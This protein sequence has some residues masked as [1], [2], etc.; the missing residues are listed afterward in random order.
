MRTGIWDVHHVLRSSK[1]QARSKSPLTE[2]L[3]YGVT[4]FVLD[5]NHLPTRMIKLPSGYF[6]GV[7]AASADTPDSFEAYK[8]ALSSTSSTFSQEPRRDM[9]LGEF[10][11]QHHNDQA[12]KQSISNAQYTELHRR[13]Q[14][15][16]QSVDN[17]LREVLQLATK[18]EGRHQEISRSFMTK[19]E[20]HTI[21]QRVKS[22][23][24]TLREYQTQFASLQGLLKDS[25]SSLNE[26][27]TQQMT[28]R[29]SFLSL[30]VEEF[31]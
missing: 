2:N 1:R 6:F 13:I 29:M 16:G 15:M 12:S 9:P 25:H 3:A 18:S 5:N 17:V 21:D 20:L 7:S 30:Q 8:F 10:S 14:V 23:E 28:H 19:D 26:G 4:R 31:G 24:N 11:S 22:I 27:L